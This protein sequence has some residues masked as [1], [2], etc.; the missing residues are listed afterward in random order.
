MLPCQ[1]Q[2]PYRELHSFHV[3]T[4]EG[5]RK[6][7]ISFEHKPDADLPGKDIKVWMPGKSATELAEKLMAMLAAL[8]R[9]HEF[10]QEFKSGGDDE[11]G[12]DT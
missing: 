5:K 4:G 6:P 7:A 9:Q 11:D 8:H 10:E 3:I 1:A 12:D 2:I